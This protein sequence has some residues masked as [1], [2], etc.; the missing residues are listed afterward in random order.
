MDHDALRADLDS[1]TLTDQE[2][3]ADWDAFEDRF[4]VF[5]S[6]DGVDERTEATDVDDAEEVG[7]AD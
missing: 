7:L 3:D 5:E 1:A 4:P 6:E 2:M